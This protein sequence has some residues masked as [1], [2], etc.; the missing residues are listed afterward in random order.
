MPSEATQR[1]RGDVVRIRTKRLPD[2]TLLRVYVLRKKGP[3]G[4]KTIADKIKR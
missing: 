1:K 4:G 3:R 2:G